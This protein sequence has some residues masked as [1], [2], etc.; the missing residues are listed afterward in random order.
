AATAI[1]ATR[2]A[3]V[4][5]RAT[6]YGHEL[7]EAAAAAARIFERRG[8]TDS[9]AAALALLYRVQHALDDESMGLT[10]RRAA[11]A[12]ERAGRVDSASRYLAYARAA[13]AEA[14]SAPESGLTSALRSTAALYLRAGRPDSAAAMLRQSDSRHGLAGK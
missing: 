6:R 5:A 14:P 7:Q 4:A 12:F 11:E 1:A 13:L 10:A 9:L 8:P 3:I 2:S